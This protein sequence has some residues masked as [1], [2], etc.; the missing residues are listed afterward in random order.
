LFALLCRKRQ[1]LKH[2]ESGKRQEEQTVEKKPVGFVVGAKQRKYLF[3]F[4]TAVVEQQSTSIA[5]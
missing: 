3:F 2:K 1:P 4:I 5:D